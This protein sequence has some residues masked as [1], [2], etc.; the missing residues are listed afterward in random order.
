MYN[1]FE[2]PFNM[3]MVYD[4]PYLVKNFGKRTSKIQ[5]FLRYKD[6]L[7]SIIIDLLLTFRHL[8]K[9]FHVFFFHYTLGIF[10]LTESRN[11]EWF[12][13]NTLYSQCIYMWIFI[14]VVIR[15]CILFTNVE[16]HSTNGKIS[17]YASYIAP[18]LCK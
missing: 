4:T 8:Q 3:H 16:V 10:F 13:L 1:V 2:K 6:F 12:F 11:M 15:S 5:P 17:F 9:M 18:M 7:S 14:E